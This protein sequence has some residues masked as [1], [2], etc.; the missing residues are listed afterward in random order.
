M[1]VAVLPSQVHVVV[2]IRDLAPKCDVQSSNRSRLL[3][4]SH[5]LWLILLLLLFLTSAPNQRTPTA[6]TTGFRYDSTTLLRSPFLVSRGGRRFLW[7]CDI[8][9]LP[10]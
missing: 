7:R 9:L 6:K 4:H 10:Q 5:L 3:A 1:T 2:A 8:R